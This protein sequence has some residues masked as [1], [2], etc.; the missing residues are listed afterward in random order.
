MGWRCLICGEV[1]P[2]AFRAPGPKK[3]VPEGARGYAGYCKEHEAEVKARVDARVA[4]FVGVRR[5]A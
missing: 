1:V 2:T 3:E 4:Q 5:T